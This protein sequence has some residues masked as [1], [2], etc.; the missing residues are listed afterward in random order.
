M[1]V[2]LTR[3]EDEAMSYLYGGGDEEVECRSV[4][5]VTIKYPQ[6]CFSIMHDGPSKSPSG[7]KMIAERAKVEGKFGTSYTCMGCIKAA[8]AELGCKH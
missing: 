8:L 4:S 3:S 2:P 1:S 6:E 7:V 5:W